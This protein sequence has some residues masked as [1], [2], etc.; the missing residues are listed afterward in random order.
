LSHSTLTR[1]GCLFSFLLLILFV[2]CSPSEQPEKS[3]GALGVSSSAGQMAG[4]TKLAP[5]FTLEN[6]AGEVLTLS[7]LRGKVV[8]VNIWATWCPPCRD[9]LPSMVKFYNAYKAKGVE[10]VAVS[11]DTTLAPVLKMVKK[12]GINF[13][14]VMDKNKGVYA[15]YG[16]TG[17]P[18]TFL[19]DKEGVIKYKKIGPF[20][21]T[22]SG[23]LRAVDGLLAQ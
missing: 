15:S 7:E 12:I 20:D 13:P 16:A 21:W 1:I 11:E 4:A 22:S 17:V 5:D 14:V 3:Q 10:I 23:F 18:E 2:G 19:L 6:I 9:E 8:L